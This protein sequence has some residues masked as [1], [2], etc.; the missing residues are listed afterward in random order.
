MEI[1]LDFLLF[2]LTTTNISFSLL[3]APYNPTMPVI[4]ST[5][6]TPMRE[7]T[8]DLMVVPKGIPAITSKSIILITSSS[9]I[10]SLTLMYIDMNMKPKVSVCNEEDLKKNVIYFQESNGYVL[11]LLLLLVLEK[12]LF[13]DI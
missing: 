6:K 7:N 10:S 1:F 5:T 12:N 3:N 8:I 11:H 2:S 9:K 13:I 4:S